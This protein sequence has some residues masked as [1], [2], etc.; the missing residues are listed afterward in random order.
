MQSAYDLWHAQ[1]TTDVSHIRP[2]KEAA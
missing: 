1:Q 2:L